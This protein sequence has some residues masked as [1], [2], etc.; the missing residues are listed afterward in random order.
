MDDPDR[1]LE[2]A[3]AVRHAGKRPVHGPVGQQAHR[4]GPRVHPEDGPVAA[5]AEAVGS[6]TR[7]IRLRRDDDEAAVGEERQV[8]R[9][10]EERV[11]DDEL[12]RPVRAR[13]RPDPSLD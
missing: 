4:P 13:D 3:V 8:V 5:P 6:E 11:L 7:G 10:G 2:R 1:I 9:V 12:G